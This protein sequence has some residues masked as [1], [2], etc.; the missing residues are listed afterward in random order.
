LQILADPK[1]KLENAD[2]LFKVVISILNQKPK[3]ET[4]YMLPCFIFVL[5]FQ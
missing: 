5:D 2:E 1:L 4:M 3:I